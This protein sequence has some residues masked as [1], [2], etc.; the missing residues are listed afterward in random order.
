MKGET[1]KMEQIIVN[2]VKP[3][4]L[5]LIPVLYFVGMGLKKS[6]DIKDKRIPYVLGTSG[7]VLSALYVFATSP[8]TS[9]QEILMAVFVALTQGIIVSGVS[10]FADQLVKQA[11]KTE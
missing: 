7:I 3:E 9:W 6:Q 5:V 2:Y 11:K 1:N 10:V 8:V 4:L